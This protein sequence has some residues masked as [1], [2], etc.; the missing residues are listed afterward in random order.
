MIKYWIAPTE[1][2]GYVIKL[3]RKTAGASG[4]DLQV[5]CDLAKVIHPCWRFT[6]RTGIHLAMSR[7]IEAQIRPRSGLTRDHGI[8]CAFGSVDSDYRGEI[9]VTLFNHGAES[10]QILPGDR[11]AQLVFS[12]VFPHCGELTEQDDFEPRQVLSRDDLELTVRG[13]SGHGSTGR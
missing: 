3:E 12:P 9:S 5:N 11:I 7:G 1:G 10:Y 2:A 8:I 13:S 6:L 4:Y